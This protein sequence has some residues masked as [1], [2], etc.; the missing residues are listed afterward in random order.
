M[1][2]NFLNSIRVRI[3]ITVI[4]LISI[5][6]AVLQ[7]SNMLL[8]YNKLKE[9][10]VYTTE[11]LSVSIATNVSEY[12]EGA[13]HQSL[14]LSQDKNIIKGT[15]E[16]E[17]T[18]VHAVSQFPYFTHLYMQDLTGM[19]TIRSSGTLANRSDRW[20]FKKMIDHPEGFVSE[21]YISVNKNVLTTSIFL[22]MYEE[23]KFVGIYGADLT[24]KQIQSNTSKYWNKDIS[25]LVLDSKGTVLTS[26]DIQPGEYINYI[27]RTKRTVVLDKNG[28]FELDD[29]GQILTTVEKIELSDTMNTIISNALDMKTQSFE[30]RENNKIVVCAYQPIKL[31]GSSDEWSVIVFQNQTDYASIFILI[32]SFIV[33]ISLCI[34][35]TFRQINH[36]VLSPVITIQQDME[37]IAAGSMDVEIYIP[38]QNEIGVLASDIN[39][40]V[41]ALKKQQQRLDEQEKMAALGMLVAGVAHEINTPLGIGVTTSTYMQKIN[42]EYRKAMVEGKFTKQDLLEFMN[43]MDESLDLLQFNLERGSNIIQSFK[44]IAVNQ[45][46]EKMETFSVKQC[47]QDIVT[48]LVHEY[49]NSGHTIL[50]ECEDDL[51]I[52]SYPGAFAQILTNFI[53]NSLTHA[54]KKKSHG[55]MQITAKMEHH[56]FVLSY[57]DD[58]CGLEKEQLSQV[59]TPF[60]TT[61]KEKGGSG[62]GLSIVYNLVTQ[63]LKGTI[64]VKSELDN[65]IEFL[66]TIPVE[67]D[68]MHG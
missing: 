57:Q 68:S 29:A 26:S 67:G 49:K 35:I 19:Q 45:T 38:E 62:L 32:I 52:Y 47:A 11:A 53:M 8:V 22:P 21:A 10:T 63:K 6:F 41:I 40:M 16:G 17:K 27:E 15:K 60:Y 51:M 42:H 66:I 30:F 59:F 58:G 20:W 28:N 37:K 13:Y 43:T 46:S 18:L 61:N 50:I 5:P 56:N 7:L 9:K 31:P 33:L 34:L 55:T 23:E 3:I 1:K 48:S 14:L 4:L 24:L 39:K 25:Y 36:H 2:K 54:F 64:G 65:G 12:V 44:K